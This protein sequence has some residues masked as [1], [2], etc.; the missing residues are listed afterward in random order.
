M[1]AVRREVSLGQEEAYTRRLRGMYAVR[2]KMR[3]TATIMA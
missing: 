3:R 1:D 2:V